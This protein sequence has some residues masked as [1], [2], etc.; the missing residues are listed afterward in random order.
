MM[1]RANSKSGYGELV[2]IAMQVL[3]VVAFA[4]LGLGAVVAQ[5]LAAPDEAIPTLHV[6]TNLVQIPAL[7]LGLD[8]EP[9]RGIAANRFYVSLDGGPRFRATHVRL[10]G[11]DAIS[12]AVVMDLSQPFPTLEKNLE[13]AMA[14]L[15]PVYL[16]ANDRVSIYSMDCGLGR[17]GLAVP[18]SA[19]TLRKA[20][21]VALGDWRA[22]GRQRWTKSCTK[23]ANLWD[24]LGMVTKQLAT[25]TG[26]RAILVMTD[27]VDRGSKATWNE[28]R[29]YA[30]AS[31]VA[32]FGLT[33]AAYGVGSFSMSHGAGE[34]EFRSMCELTGGDVL[35]VRPSELSEQLMQF[36]TLLRER[37][38]VEFPHAV[39]TKGGYHDME[40][41]INR[42]DAAVYAAG[43]SIPVDDPKVLNDPTT[44][45]VDPMDA[46]QLGKRKV[47][48]P[49]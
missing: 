32:I 30:Q 42:S 17:A 26:R 29:L 6:Y 40:I 24:S 22:H 38:I 11:D 41:T 13:D 45:H 48:A 10:Q 7:V 47:V 1:R 39:D 19:E 5:E 18:A 33:Q 37:Y 27:G 16:H 28:L 35:T 2:Q 25:Q 43:D 9:A 23:P 15:A 31:G 21:G 4:A 3:G 8:G 20:T 49:N 36:T 34:N 14:G 44:I 12:L 46:P